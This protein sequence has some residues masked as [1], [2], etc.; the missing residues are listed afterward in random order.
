[1]ATLGQPP[2]AL[3]PLCFYSDF[4]GFLAPPLTR[5]LARKAEFQVGKVGLGGCV[6]PIRGEQCL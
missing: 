5:R 4:S 3:G 2:V 6:F 1:M